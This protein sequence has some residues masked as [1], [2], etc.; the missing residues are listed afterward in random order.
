MD[1]TNGIKETKIDAD[2]EGKLRKHINYL[3]NNTEESIIATERQFWTD[4]C[5]S[6]GVATFLI[7]RHVEMQI[8]NALSLK[9]FFDMMSEEEIEKYIQKELENKGL[10]SSKEEQK[11]MKLRSAL[12][13]KR[14]AEYYKQKESLNTTPKR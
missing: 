1:K 13:A 4:K 9:D 12:F 10:L 14:E 3:R 6:D 2:R 5:I 8:I 11:E 7:E